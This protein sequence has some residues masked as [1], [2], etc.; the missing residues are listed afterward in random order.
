MPPASRIADFHICVVHPPIPLPIAKGANAV[1]IGFSPASRMGDE[2][3]CP[4]NGRIASGSPTVF[5]EN[6]PAARIGD[7]TFPP[8]LV[9]TGYPTVNIGTS[10][11]AGAL[12]AAALLGLP[13]CE[14]C[15]SGAL[16][17]AGSETP[18][19]AGTVPPA[20]P[21]PGGTAT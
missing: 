14:E 20:A 10:A 12:M 7:V 18:P 4:A 2:I 6:K 5:I 13:F 1:F 17:G 21:P 16:G 11:Q 19:P 8:G 9:V 3:A 15:A